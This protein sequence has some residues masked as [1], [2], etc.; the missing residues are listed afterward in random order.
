[1]FATYLCDI[2][3]LQWLD[4]RSNMLWH[5]LKVKFGNSLQRSHRS[6]NINKKKKEIIKKHHL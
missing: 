2:T 3:H 1:M 4:F 6:A 5:K